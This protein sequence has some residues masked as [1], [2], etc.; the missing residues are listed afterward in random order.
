MNAVTR[1][2]DLSCK[3]L[4]PTCVGLLIELASLLVGA[5]FIAS[6]NLVSV[7][8]EY[9]L[10]LRVYRLVPRLSY[11]EGVD[12][13]YCNKYKIFVKVIMKV[14]GALNCVII[15]PIPLHGS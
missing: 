3:V 8:W 11:K 15:V 2:L 12:G 10:L 14:T 9:A 7:F 4:A 6:W 1:S 13:R 5:V